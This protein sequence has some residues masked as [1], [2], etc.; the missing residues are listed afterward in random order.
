MNTNNRS[1]ILDIKD[2]MQDIQ[3]LEATLC[4]Y[5]EFIFTSFVE[6]EIGRQRSLRPPVNL[7]SY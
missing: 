7:Q 1:L 6:V 2:K 4:T 3:L 5:K